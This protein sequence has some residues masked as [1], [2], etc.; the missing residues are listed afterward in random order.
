MFNTRN[1]DYRDYLLFYFVL[2]TEF[3]NAKYNK[4]TLLFFFIMLALYT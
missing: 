2:L 4:N 3:W 1:R